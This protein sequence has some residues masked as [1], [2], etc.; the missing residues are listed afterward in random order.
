[1]KI[2]VQDSTK[3][4]AALDEVQKGCRERTYDAKDIERFA[5]EW[6][7]HLRKRG[8][9]TENLA[10]CEYLFGGWGRPARSY[11]YPYM[12]TVGKIVLGSGTRAFLVEVART[13]ARNV[14]RGKVTE[15]AKSD[16]VSRAVELAEEIDL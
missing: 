1:M 3:V 2:N 10:G 5:E 11:K 14:G 13:Y 7:E 15:E 4:Q 12:G 16:L 9:K 8:V 6:R